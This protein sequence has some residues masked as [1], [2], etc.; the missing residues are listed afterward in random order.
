MDTRSGNLGQTNTLHHPSPTGANSQA[1]A[2]G[3]SECY[4]GETTSPDAEGDA[5][6]NGALWAR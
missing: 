5:F 6:V 4:Y 3:C 2:G 1:T